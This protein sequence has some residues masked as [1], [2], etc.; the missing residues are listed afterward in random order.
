[1][2]VTNKTEYLLRIRDITSQFA[3]VDLMWNTLKSM[4]VMVQPS[5]LASGDKNSTNNKN[6]QHEQRLNVFLCAHSFNEWLR[7]L[8]M[9]YSTT[10]RYL[11]EYEAGK[12]TDIRSFL[13]VMLHRIDHSYRPEIARYMPVLQTVLASSFVSPSSV[14]PSTASSAI[15]Q[16]YNAGHAVDI[17]DTIVMDADMLEIAFVEIRQLCHALYKDE[18]KT[19]P[20]LEWQ[21]VQVNLPV[22]STHTRFE[23]YTYV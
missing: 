1:M 9:F 8:Y 17:Y 22:K 6:I 2:I 16:K 20:T 18:L 10:V 13:L 14:S 4:M 5:L 23:S 7:V 19:D 15:H 3:Y 21:D 11:R 12:A